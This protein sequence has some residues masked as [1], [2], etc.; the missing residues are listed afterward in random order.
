MPA[1][2]HATYDSAPLNDRRTRPVKSIGISLSSPTSIVEMTRNVIELG[3]NSTPQV[4]NE[5]PS[6][7]SY[8]VTSNC[9]TT[10]SIRGSGESG[11]SD[12]E[13]IDSSP[14]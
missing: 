4:S 3:N 11:G 1:V 10:Y 7:L 13:N 6:N 2:N 12:G 9:L 8:S 14:V 5:L